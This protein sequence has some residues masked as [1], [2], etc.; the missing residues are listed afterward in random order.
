[1]PDVS[2]VDKV[3]DYSVPEKFATRLG[4]GD[5]VRVTL[6][7]RRVGGWVVDINVSQSGEYE[8]S[9]I[10]SVSGV[11]V[12]AD[13]VP[14]TEQVARRWG[15]SWRS[16]LVSASAP[17]VRLERGSAS[18]RTK[19]AQGEIDVPVGKH[20]EP[21]PDGDVLVVSPP[22]ISVMSIVEQCA[23][24]GPTLV[25]CPTVKMAS[26]GAASLRRRGFSVASYPDGW[27][28]AF[29]GVDV[30]IGPRSAVWAP[31]PGLSAIV[32]IDEHDEAH[33]EERVP[34][35]NAL[36]VAQL[37]AS[38]VGARLVA[39]S[40]F[41]SLKSRAAFSKIVHEAGG[42]Q[43]PKIEV[44]D[45]LDP[46]MTGGLRSNLLTRPLLES[47]ADMGTAGSTTVMILNTKG[48]ARLLV[49]AACQETQRCSQCESVVSQR[50]D[51][52]FQCPKC[53][54]TRSPLCQKCG[55]TSFRHV[56]LGSTNVREQLAASTKR[57]V[58]DVQGY[59]AGRADIVVDSEAALHRVDDASTVCF[60]DIDSELESGRLDALTS[61]L[62]SVSRAAR[63]VGARGRVLLQSRHPSHP[64]LV[65]LSG[66]SLEEVL[67]SEMQMRRSLQLPPFSL[68]VEA[69]GDIHRLDG[70]QMPLGCALAKVSTDRAL[71][72]FTDSD[73]MQSVLTEVKASLGRHVRLAV[74]PYRQ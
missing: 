7:N 29:G 38:R 19:Q 40:A 50:D 13:M 58:V 48:R 73:I 57:R 23:A 21:L 17:K 69:T 11:G 1:V 55:R 35:W 71:L 20:S 53:D 60:L 12:V 18:R 42:G 62:S 49:C 59:E 54:A 70:I 74:E 27:S 44:V 43:W 31:C 8:L 34:T 28:E 52:V 41:G 10:V 5:K 14:V 9:P 22:S 37:R 25:I 46:E 24:A 56:R 36:D 68:I 64:V 3:F 30:V 2:G 65:A 39:T 47:A 63:L 16:V 72:R 26:R 15:G 66:G 4:I 61:T 67:D 33:W 45:L 6:N 51:E 32:V